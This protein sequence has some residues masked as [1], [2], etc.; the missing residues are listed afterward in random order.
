MGIIE[1]NC[2]FNKY[3][4]F[5]AVAEYKSFSK[6]AE[7]LYVSQ[8]A[9]SY[10]IKEI[11]DQLNTKLF[12]RNKKNVVLTDEGEKLLYYIKEALDN[13]ITGE[14]MIKE[15]ADD[16]KGV[17]RIGIYSHVA[18]F[19]LPKVMKDFNNKYPNAR[20]DVYSSSNAEMVEMLR[21]R[22]LDFILLQYPIFLKEN[23]LKEEF[24]CELENCFFANKNYYDLININHNNII[25]YPLLLP[26]RGFADISNLEEI[27]K[28]NNL[29]LKNQHTIY[30]CEINKALVKEGLGIGWGI[31]KCLE[32]EIKHK[33]I[34][35]IP[36]D[37]PT[38]TTKFSIAY[39]ER[40]LSKTTKEFIK[41]LKKELK[42]ISL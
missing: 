5:Y 40:F 30:T 15:K 25:D 17:I 19:M 39:D 23:N 1:N 20:F 26:K 4:F 37:F 21:N 34:Y 42:K 2:D 8:P 14:R 13:I 10:A 24:V 38:P 29:K 12:V 36:V 7:A 35:I 33:E 3:R 18:Q 11:E 32:N 28:K 16:L 41:Y 9:I 22:E 31:K 6:A 27:L